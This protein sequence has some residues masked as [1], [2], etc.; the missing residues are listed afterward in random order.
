MVRLMDVLPLEER[1][2]DGCC[3]W[4]R[5]ELSEASASDLASAVAIVADALIH[6]QC[7]GAAALYE[8]WR[9][10]VENERSMAANDSRRLVPFIQ[11]VLGLPAKPRTTE[12]VEGVV[13]EYAWFLLAQEH[14]PA[15]L[16]LRTIEGPGFTV[17][18]PGG[19]GLVVYQRDD[20]TLMFRLWEIKKH[21]SSA[22]VSRTVGTAYGQ[23]EEKA[24]RY[25]AQLTTLAS[26]YET[27]VAELY[28]SLSD[29]WLERDP[30][31]GAGVAV[32][33]SFD[34]L[35]ETCFGTMHKRFPDLGVEQIGGLVVGLGS[36]P[37]FA[38]AVRDRIWNAL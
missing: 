14:Q 19:D 34:K 22:H 26:Q 2:E 18:A 1:G 21:N 9:E 12:H 23:L 30:R 29:L 28:S 17:S 11:P 10:A 7:R 36:F 20:S 27:D 6:Y 4:L 25:L 24:E 5:G 8:L 13:A 16:E 38:L 32:S 15:G 37:A 31:A 3:L 35:P 33:T